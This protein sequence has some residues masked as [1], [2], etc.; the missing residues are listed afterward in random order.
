MTH[1]DEKY[2]GVFNMLL[3]YFS[4][5]EGNVHSKL[6]LKLHFKYSFIEIMVNQE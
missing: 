5:D 3:L 2:F 4:D 6:S 1:F